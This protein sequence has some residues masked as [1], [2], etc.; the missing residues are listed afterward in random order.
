[1]SKKVKKQH[2]DYTKKGFHIQYWF[3]DIIKWIFYTQIW[4]WQRPKYYYVDKTKKK[5]LKKPFMIV[6]NHQG[7]GD[8][9]FIYY[10]FFLKRIWFLGHQN[11]FKKKFGAFVFKHLLC[12][13]ID[14]STNSFAALRTLLDVLKND[15]IVAVFPEGHINFESNEVK[16]FKAGASFLALQSGVDIVP[17]YRERR[18]H[19]WQRQRV[20]IG[21]PYNLKTILGGAGSRNDLDKANKIIYEKEQELKALYQN[22]VPSKKVQRNNTQVFLSSYPFKCSKSITPKAR[23][24]EIESCKSDKTKDEKF[25]SWK[26]LE[27]VFREEYG[28]S[29]KSLHFRK[30]DNGKWVCKDWNVSI[31]HSGS[32]IA[33]AISKNKVGIDIQK[34]EE[35]NLSS[36]LV[37]KVFLENEKHE[38]IDEYEFAKVWGLKESSFK[39]SNDTGFNPHNYDTISINRYDYKVIR[40]ENKDYSLVVIDDSNDMISYHFMN[41]EIRIK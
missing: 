37:D 35:V 27:K 6:S 33:I 13:P 40:H 22:I 41:P 28:I 2:L 12:I 23:K 11:M 14:P 29:I 26:L 17:M 38:N 21:E 25:Y 24:E 5:N 10:A 30:Q 18:K 32:L 1:M 16:D 7:F 4:L 19:W 34:I 20:I 3:L 8:N 39:L 36:G 9:L 15:N 31:S